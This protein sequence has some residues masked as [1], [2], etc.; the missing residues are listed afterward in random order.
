MV[1]DIRV[2]AQAPSVRLE[3]PRRNKDGSASLVRPARLPVPGHTYGRL[4]A[5]RSASGVDRGIM[6]ACRCICGNEVEVNRYSL[7][8][9]TTK[10]C[11]CIK[12]ERG[13]N[14]YRTHGLSRSPEHRVWRSILQRCL[15]PSSPSYAYYGGRGIT[16]CEEWR[17]S[18]MAFLAVV[19]ERPS[20]RHSID[21][22]DPNGNYEP[23]NVRWAT[24]K[25]QARNRRN[26]RIVVLDGTSM[27]LTDAAERIGW[28]FSKLQARLRR[29]G[30]TDVRAVMTEPTR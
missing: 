7:I 6:W 14:G 18:F 17:R 26:N 21:R 3:E 13:Y 10:S 4:T 5:L 1:T 29:A 23:G 27:C 2:A 9:G 15:L 28:S 30:T 22:I 16:V 12:K 24:P 25:E 11:G 19:G 8:A 20:L